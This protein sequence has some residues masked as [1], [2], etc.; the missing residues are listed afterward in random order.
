MASF[1]SNSIHLR[2]QEAGILGIL[3][4]LK[5]LTLVK[6]A[7]NITSREI[8]T[9]TFKIDPPDKQ[10]F[11]Q[12]YIPIFI[13]HLQQFGFII[14]R[15]APN[16]VD[17]V[18][19][20]K[21]NLMLA[22]LPT[23]DVPNPLG[24][25]SHCKQFYVMD[26]YIP[27]EDIGK[28]TYH[29]YIMNRPEFDEDGFMLHPT[30]GGYDA[31]NLVIHYEKRQNNDM[32]RDVNNST[33]G[34][35]T[36]AENKNNNGYQDIFDNDTAVIDGQTID[37]LTNTIERGATVA[38]KEIETTAQI[39]NAVEFPFRNS[40]VQQTAYQTR[41]QD[42][43]TQMTTIAQSVA[44]CYRMPKYM[45]M[46]MEPT[47]L[48]GSAEKQKKEMLDWSR[49]IS[50]LR[51]ICMRLFK[52]F[53]IHIDIITHIQPDQLPHILCVSNSQFGMQMFADTYG[54]SQSEIDP[55]R[56]EKYVE[57][58]MPEIK[59]TGTKNTKRAHSADVEESER[60]NKKAHVE[61]S[62]FDVPPASTSSIPN[63]SSDTSDSATSAQS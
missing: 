10:S 12:T 3:S 42:F 23:R 45:A 24:K 29:V 8:W 31:M 51:L 19:P 59:L 7:L 13:R 16:G 52:I 50:D 61:K 36:V 60:A 18:D 6:H 28:C 43:S 63:N 34:F 54:I 9:P 57:N 25:L 55:I 53:N 11:V 44:Q 14:L 30:S 21:S 35:F 38:A 49:F 2:G 1:V 37:D 48:A 46:G 39:M 32:T 26:Y 41:P 56:Y 20:C 58:I 15:E 22:K 27:E 33:H 47:N 4:K 5:G 62:Q 40:T 17:V